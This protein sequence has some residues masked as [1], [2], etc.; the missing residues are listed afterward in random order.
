MSR[1]DDGRFIKYLGGLV[2]FFSQKDAICTSGRLLR[3][4][5]DEVSGCEA[6]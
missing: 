4:D 6:E 1:D 5:N 3:M 2:D